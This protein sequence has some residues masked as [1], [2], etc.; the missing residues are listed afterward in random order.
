[1]VAVVAPPGEFGRLL[2]VGE[3][4]HERP[5]DE[6]RRALEVLVRD[7]GHARAGG[8]EDHREDLGGRLVL[9]AAGGVDVALDQVVDEPRQA[10]AD[11][12]Q[13]EHEGLNGFHA[14]CR[15]GE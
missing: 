1:M 2:D 9:A 3:Q 7:G 5:S 4:H 8:P 12:E 10:V 6:L 11:V 13:R 14:L 15:A